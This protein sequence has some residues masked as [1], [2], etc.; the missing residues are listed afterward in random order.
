LWLGCQIASFSFHKISSGRCG[1]GAWV[2]RRVQMM[3]C[4][5]EIVGDGV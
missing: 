4:A 5:C 2:L 3:I 1:L